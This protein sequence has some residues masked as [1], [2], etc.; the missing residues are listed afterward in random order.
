MILDIL[1]IIIR[2]VV[3]VTIQVLVLNNV[4]LGGF[5]NPLL[6]VLFLLTLPVYTPR[7]LLLAVAMITGLMIDMFQNTMGMHAS[8]CLLL[9]YVRPAWLKIIAPRDG[10]DTEAVPSIRQFGIRWFLAYAGVLIFIHHF[11]LFFI[12]IFR[13]SE[14]MNTLLRILISTIVTLLLVILSQFMTMRPERDGK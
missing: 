4:E 13:M 14:F 6:Y 3:L 1:R 8:A 7:L 5:I 11:A 2:F 9:A 10:Y 12:E